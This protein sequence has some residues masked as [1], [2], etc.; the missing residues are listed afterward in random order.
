M[1]N[2]STSPLSHKENSESG[3]AVEECMSAL[4]PAK[5][6]YLKA[7]AS[8]ISDD[9]SCGQGSVYFTFN[10]P[11]FTDY[12]KVNCDTDM[13]GYRIP[14]SSFNP[15]FDVF[16]FEKESMTLWIN[17][18]KYRFGLSGIRLRPA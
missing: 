15:D 1:K 13:R 11:N 18:G 2:P 9:P 14:H 8:F 16:T 5:C 4:N 7:E 10:W 6:E 17:S 12:P 3:M